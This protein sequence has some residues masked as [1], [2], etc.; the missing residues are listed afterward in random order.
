M[1]DC[2][3][4]S[5]HDHETIG[6]ELFCRHCRTYHKQT[7]ICKMCGSELFE[8]NELLSMMEGKI[9]WSHKDNSKCD[10]P[11]PVYPKGR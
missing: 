4:Q 2:H 5:Y 10:D 9:V 1:V 3:T 8:T 6:E 11:V 7:Y